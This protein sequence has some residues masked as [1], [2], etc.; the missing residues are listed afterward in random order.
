MA[1]RL[2]ASAASAA[3]WSLG[4]VGAV[5]GRSTTLTVASTKRFKVSRSCGMSHSRGF[6]PRFRRFT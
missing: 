4:V 2:A 5:D 6:C 3:A 1:A